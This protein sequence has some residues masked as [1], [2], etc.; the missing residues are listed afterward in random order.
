[1]VQSP[2]TEVEPTSSIN[3]VVRIPETGLHLES[4]AK[5]ADTLP[6]QAF[7]LTIND[8]VIEDLIKCVQDG[9]E[10]KLSLGNTPVSA[11]SLLVPNGGGSI[12]PYCSAGRT[13]ASQWDEA[14]HH[15]RS[16][17]N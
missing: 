11:H 2:D 7:A 5:S 8:N 12:V 4:S 17:L 1:M 3:M 15:H 10:P 16:A 9:G 6:L 13:I 14:R